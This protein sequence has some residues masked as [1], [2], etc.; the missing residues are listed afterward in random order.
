MPSIEEIKKLREETSVG[1]SD[2]KKALEESKGDFEKAK[3]W[4]RKKGL[5]K[6]AEKASRNANEGFIG[7]YVHQNGKIGVI[8]E[9]NCETDFVARTDTFKDF[10]HDVAMHIAAFAPLHV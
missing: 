1:V 7:S 2:A 5:S 3:E 8:V 10:A 6:S 9:I 4:L